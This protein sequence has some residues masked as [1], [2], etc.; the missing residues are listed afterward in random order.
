MK[1]ENLITS[2]FS[3][4]ILSIIVVGIVIFFIYQQK[5]IGIIFVLLGLLHIFVL[6]I[7]GIIDNGFLVLAA[8]VG[9]DFA[10]VL[11]AIIGGA[12]ANAITDGFAGI[13]EGKTAE[14]VRKHKIEEK[15]TALSSSLGKMAGCFFGAG[16]V[17]II[18]W[19]IL[20]L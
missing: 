3:V 1:K 12:T 4:I 18:M 19:T 7:F 20:S 5:W 14:Y 17:L 2:I 13:F 11:G 9:A 16:I 10:G 6:N 15:R 8:I